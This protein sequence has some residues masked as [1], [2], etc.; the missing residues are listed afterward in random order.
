MNDPHR[1]GGAL[2][3][4]EHAASAAPRAPWQPLTV[5][6]D[7]SALRARVEAVR[8]QLHSPDGRSVDL[9]VAA[10]TEQFGLVARLVSAHVC[11]RALGLS[12]DL[13]GDEIWW[14]QR[15]GQLLRL[16]LA[17]SPHQRNPLQHGAIA[18]VT[19]TIQR[20]Y[21]V[22]AQVLWGNVG[23][24]A[25]STVTLLRATRPDLVERAQKAADELL[26]DP[27][28]D[29]GALRTG[30]NF[31]RHSC[32]LIYRAGIGMCGDCVLHP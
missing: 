12:L 2:A 7:E 25:N 19:D 5:R 27:R 17:R 10:S 1:L 22:S 30:T 3:F 31:R 6:T 23:S 4:D 13:A 26:H 24:A 14:Q 21:G 9:R 8:A 20:L 16:S 28:I 32:C 15:P 18:Q 11:A 29:G